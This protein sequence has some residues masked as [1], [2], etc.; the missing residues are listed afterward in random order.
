MDVV[1]DF[2]WTTKCKALTGLRLMAKYTQTYT[3]VVVLGSM[4]PQILTHNWLVKERIIPKKVFDSAAQK[5]NP[6][7]QFISTPP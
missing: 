4:N 2:F 6:F 5:G 3:N 1:G 7:T